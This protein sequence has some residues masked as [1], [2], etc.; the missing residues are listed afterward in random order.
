MGSKMNRKFYE[1]PY[2]R[3]L[4]KVKY[5]VE[6]NGSI[7][8]ELNEAFTSK[9]DALTLE[10]IEF[11]NKYSGERIKRGLY[12]SKNGKRINGD[13][14]GAINIKRKYCG[15][16]F[17][18]TKVNLLNPIKIKTKEKLIDDI[19]CSIRNKANQNSVIG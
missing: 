15:S 12:L 11:H 14:N 6:E 19:R 10:T 16:E 1:I 5:K 18:F 4:D 7:Y 17:E 2:R 3:L 13:L 8:K 9:C